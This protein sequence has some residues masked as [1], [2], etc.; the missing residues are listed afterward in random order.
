MR[1]SLTFLAGVPPFVAELPFDAFDVPENNR[2]VGLSPEVAERIRDAV[3]M[4]TF[5]VFHGLAA[6]CHAIDSRVAAT[7][8]AAAHV[9][10]AGMSECDFI[11]DTLS[12]CSGFDL[13]AAQPATA[14]I[15]SVKAS[16]LVERP[17]FEVT[18]EGGCR[19]AKPAE[20][21]TIE[22]A[23]DKCLAQKS[24]GAI[25]VS[26][27]RQ[28]RLQIDTC[29]AADGSGNLED[30]GHFTVVKRTGVTSYE[31]T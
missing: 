27:T 1:K 17:D 4:P 24:C 11:D 8:D 7:N 16:S 19:D 14:A 29:T 13:A 20:E 31:N 30:Y 3:E 28:N 6:R 23:L 21:A 2:S 10:C 18:T 12:L 22:T 25:R 9:L 26:F 5:I 15:I